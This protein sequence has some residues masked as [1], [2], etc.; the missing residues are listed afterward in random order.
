MRVKCRVYRACVDNGAAVMYGIGSGSYA[1]TVMA[2]RNSGKTD[3]RISLICVIEER[4]ARSNM[5]FQ[6]KLLQ[7]Q[8]TIG[9]TWF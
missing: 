4:I 3:T 6:I 5:W 7:M 8:K 2:E 9:L 1:L